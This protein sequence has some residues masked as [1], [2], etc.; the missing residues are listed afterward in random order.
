[1]LDRVLVIA[2]LVTSSSLREKVWPS[3]NSTSRWISSVGRTVSPLSFTDE[4]V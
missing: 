4:I 3:F 1:M 2:S